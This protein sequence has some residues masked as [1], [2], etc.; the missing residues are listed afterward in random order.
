M[1]NLRRRSPLNAVE[2]AGVAAR[3]SLW[4][5]TAA[6]V[7]SGCAAREVH[8]D[9]D[10]SDAGSTNSNS[11]PD[12]IAPGVSVVVEDQETAIRIAV[13]ETRIYWQSALPN[14]WAEARGKPYARIRSC[15]KSDCRSTITTYDSITFIWQG[16]QTHNEYF[17]L[18]VGGDNVYWAQYEGDARLTIWTCPSAGC[19]GAPRA[20]VSH[21]GLA[22]MAVDDT[23]VYWTSRDDTA[24]LRL[25]LTGAGTP[26]AIAVN[27]PTPGQLVVGATHVYWIANA[28]QSSAAIKRAPKDGSEPAVTLAKEQNQASS[29]AIDEGFVYWANSYLVGTISRCPL[30]GCSDAPTVLIADQNRP[31]ALVVDGTSIFWMSLVGNLGPH[32]TWATVMRCP[33]NGCSS[34]TETWA[35]QTFAPTGMAMTADQNHVY[36]VAQGKEEPMSTGF[37]PQATIYRRAK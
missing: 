30:S 27:E 4:I 14:S 13:D 23:H 21:I 24:I 9:G 18:A 12:A 7:S 19:V 2:S 1:R 37:Y 25:P 15:L 8:L 3:I 32:M 36:W 35:V 11:S 20:V 6:F 22:S 16:P 34:A 17:A 5:A 31:R 29:L 33:V 28:G 10:P 26:H